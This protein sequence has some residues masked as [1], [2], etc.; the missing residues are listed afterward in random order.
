[1]TEA[2]VVCGLNGATRRRRR[3]LLGI[4]VE[5]LSVGQHLNL[6]GYCNV[7][8]AATFGGAM[9]LFS[10]SAKLASALAAGKVAYVR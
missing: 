5:R 3:Q 7:R 8:P 10:L 6:Q 9:F 2:V 4:Q 1:M